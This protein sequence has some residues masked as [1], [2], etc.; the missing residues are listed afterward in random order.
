MPIGAAA[1]S[2]KRRPRGAVFLCRALAV[3]LAP[4][5]AALAQEITID[6][7]EQ[8]TENR[9]WNEAGN[10]PTYQIIVTA[11]VAPSGLPT[12]VYAE[13]NGVREPLTHYALPAAPDLYIHWRRFDPASTGPW[14]IV[15][16]R[17]A[18]KGK[19][20]LTPAVANPQKVPL[21]RNV[22]VTGKGTGPRLSW[23]LPNL[24]GFDVDRIRV[25]VRGGKR[26]QG[27]FLSVLHVSPD[28]PP[29][30]TAFRIPSGVL[31]AGEQYVFQVS[32]DDLEGGV[33]ENRSSAFS[34]PYTA[35]R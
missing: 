15:A 12:L 30:A 24:K 22:R 9:G 28:L 11:T 4:G 18:A 29:G 13:Q 31:A 25:S 34:K 2:G 10:S 17:G 21:A 14:R 27:R 33:L 1:R 19:P 6:R 16:E 7:L 3:L 20:A 35:S 23:R 5:S 8:Y 26:V 32:L